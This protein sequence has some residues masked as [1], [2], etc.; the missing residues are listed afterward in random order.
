MAARWHI[1]SNGEPAVC[2]AASEEK[3]PLKTYDDNGNLVKRKHYDTWGEASHAAEEASKLKFRKIEDD[4]DIPLNSLSRKYGEQKTA[5]AASGNVPLPPSPDGN[6][7]LPPS[8][9]GNVPLPHPRPVGGV[10]LP[11]PR[12]VRTSLTAVEEGSSV[13][14]GRQMAKTASAAFDHVNVPLPPPPTVYNVPIPRPTADGNGNVP[15]PPQ[16]PADVPA[17]VPMPPR[18]PADGSTS[19]L[20][21]PQPPAGHATAADDKIAPA[22]F[23]PGLTIREKNVA[24]EGLVA[25]RPDLSYEK[26][27]GEPYSAAGYGDYVAKVEDKLKTDL[28]ARA[29]LSRAVTQ[30]MPPL[31]PVRGAKRANRITR[32]QMWEMLS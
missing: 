6:V 12:P 26:V 2:R 24:L 27:M 18:P 11:P 23:L 16:P 25:A 31:P 13:R 22:G 10:P 3:C 20:T 14:A 19:V 32:E 29:A 17:N 5:R 9:D 4:A 8:P 15:L 7:S 21:P 1:N 28:E 30:A